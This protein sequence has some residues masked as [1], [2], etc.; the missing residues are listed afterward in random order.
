MYIRFKDEKGQ[1][2]R[3]NGAVKSLHTFSFFTYFDKEHTDF[4]CLTAVNQDILLP[5]TKTA[6]S[7]VGGHDVLLF[8]EEGGLTLHIKGEKSKVY[9]K[10][11]AILLSSGEDG[12]D[13]AFENA[14]E[15][16]NLE[17]YAFYFNAEDA[18]KH[19]VQSMAVA[20]KDGL[21]SIVMPT[22]QAKGHMLLK[23]KDVRVFLLHGDLGSQVNYPI[24]KGRQL[25][26]EVLR[27]EVELEQGYDEENMITLKEG[28][29]VG[30]DQRYQKLYFEV[31]EGL[32]AIL[33]DMPL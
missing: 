12:L 10:N 20:L 26:V 24:K 8:V 28:D 27:G 15:K 29:A 32:E 13:V 23:G 11:D 31:Q 4:G 5:L 21:K 22:M 30:L 19:A 33:I 25:W 14:S 16:E 6:F 17:L 7:H 1:T 9:E 3:Q 18:G 2:A